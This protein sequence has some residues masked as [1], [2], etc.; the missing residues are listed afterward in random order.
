MKTIQIDGYNFIAGM[1]W[2]QLSG[3]SLKAEVAAYAN[4]NNCKYGVIRRIT[5]N[6]VAQIQLGMLSE[7]INKPW[8]AAGVLADLYP[9][10]V[11]VDFIQDSYWICAI[12]GGLVLPGGDLIVKTAE[13]VTNKID[14]ILALIGND[15]ADMVF[16][17]QESIS[18]D[19]GVTGTLNKGFAE[20]VQ[21]N[22]KNYGL[23]NQ[24]IGLKGVP[25]ALILGGVFVLLC[26]GL[27]YM[28][29]P[30]ET[31]VLPQDDFSDLTEMT[32]PGNVKFSASEMASGVI[33]SS[34]S[35]EK[36][37]NAAKQ[38]EL[39]WL[40]DDFNAND[41]KLLIQNFVN[42]YASIPPEL[43]GWVKS[44]ADYDTADQE[45]INIIW[46]KSYGTGLMLK[47]SLTQKDVSV[48][49]SLDG[50]K[51]SSYYKIPK[52]EKSNISDVL[53]FIKKAD[54]KKLSITND[55]DLAGISWSALRHTDTSRPI[56][57]EGIKD[58][59]IAQTRQLKSNITDMKVEGK[60]INN[61]LLTSE[62][63]D[64]AKSFL[65]TRI[66][67]QSENQSWVVYGALYE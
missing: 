67:I 64:R 28:L 13:E 15:T 25:K 47:N 1:K 66:V 42:S 44:G 57:I 32:L 63:L 58:K 50:K 46:D 8:S 61:L 16:A 45:K 3:E 12:S 26:G 39:M 41:N 18:D 33:S 65:T 31:S 4:E 14:D 48:A 35:D 34:A 6:G 60:G 5:S 10:I 24:I 9:N 2:S 29:M 49:I 52:V 43:S 51:G 54:Y 22:V 53:G 11:L 30:S 62:V 37:L 21:G 17:I 59:N 23:H 38:E 27:F 55:L 7:K 36:L 20:I 19:L 40:T 56:A